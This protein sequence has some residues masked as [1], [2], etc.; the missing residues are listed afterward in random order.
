M[1]RSMPILLLTFTLVVQAAAFGQR[2]GPRPLAATDM[3]AITPLVKL[4]DTPPPHNEG[5][6]TALSRVVRS[7]D[8]VD[9]LE[10]GD[11]ITGA[12]IIR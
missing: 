3:D 12:R 11:K 4:E 7:M 5:D 10:P 1:K 8:A 9:R 6:F 2:T